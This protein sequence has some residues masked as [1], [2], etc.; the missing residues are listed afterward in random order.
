MGCHFILQGIFLTQGSNLH[1]LYLLCWQ[2]DS[3]P[4]HHLGFLDLGGRMKTRNPG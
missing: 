4:L 1:L 3:L 2:V